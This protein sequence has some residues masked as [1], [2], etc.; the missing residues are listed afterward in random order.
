MSDANFVPAYGYGGFWRR[1][2]AVIIDTLIIGAVLWVLGQFLPVFE[3]ASLHATGD[4]GLNADAQLTSLGTIIAIVG[5]WLYSALLESSARGATV[6]KIALG[7]RVT[8]LAGGRI[9]F[10]QATGRYFAKFLS[11]LII[12]IGYIM[13][14]FTARK[15]ALHDML[16]GTLVV[17]S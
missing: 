5:A 10:G 15:Q 3:N 16:A 7:L 6:G 13:A 12:A 11:G 9:S 14:A 2:V 4:F 8:N 17:K 1:F